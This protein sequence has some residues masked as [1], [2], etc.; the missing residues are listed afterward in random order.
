MGNVS[1]QW[2]VTGRSREEVEMGEETTCFGPV[3]I[4]ADEADGFV[5]EGD[6][7]VEFDEEV[8]AEYVDALPFQCFLVVCSMR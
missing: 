7:V 2:N 8:G 1:F 6:D 3:G 5:F 4:A